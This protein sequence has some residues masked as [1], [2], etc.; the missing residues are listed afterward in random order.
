VVG[1]NNTV[2]S[3]SE[4]GIIP[5]IVFNLGDKEPSY[6]NREDKNC[7]KTNSLLILLEKQILMF[8]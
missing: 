3:V 6:T 1:S 4:K 5:H 8:F 7:S 2:F